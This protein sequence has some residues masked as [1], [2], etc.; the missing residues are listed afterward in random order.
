MLLICSALFFCPIKINGDCEDTPSDCVWNNQRNRYICDIVGIPKDIVIRRLQVSRYIPDIE[1]VDLIRV[2]APPDIEDTEILWNK[3]YIT[4]F[5]SC[6]ST[7]MS[8]Q[9]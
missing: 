6:M 8:V 3:E 5:V 7:T 1:S 4:L 2:T 9:C